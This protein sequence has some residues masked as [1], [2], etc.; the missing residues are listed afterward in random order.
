MY[1]RIC[2]FQSRR[3]KISVTIEQADSCRGGNAAVG[4]KSS[5]RGET[6]EHSLTA[7]ED[8]K[9]VVADDTYVERQRVCLVLTES[10]TSQRYFWNCM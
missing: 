9:V 7:V 3:G 8:G 2:C 6:D 1:Q 5:D 10:R 4:L